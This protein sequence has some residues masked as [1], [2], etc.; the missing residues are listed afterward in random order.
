MA[1]PKSYWLVKSEPTAYGWEQLV[2]DGQTEW[3]GIR[4]FEARNNLRAMALRDV[5]FFYHSVEEKQVVGLAKVSRTAQPDATAPGE[6][7]ASV[8]LVPVKPLRSPVTLEQIRKD[9]RLR[10]FPLLTRGRLSVVP[11]TPAQAHCVLQLGKTRL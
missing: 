7:W 1:R 9:K 6:D 5:V 3:T 10:T 2:K 8:E 11:V 4:N